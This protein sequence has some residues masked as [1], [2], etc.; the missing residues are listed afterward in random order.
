MLPNYTIC[1][2]DNLSLAYDNRKFPTFYLWFFSHFVYPIK[3]EDESTK[4]NKQIV[5]LVM[6]NERTETIIKMTQITGVKYVVIQNV[7]ESALF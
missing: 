2:A 7:L 1:F 4:P 3:L 6:L 5:T